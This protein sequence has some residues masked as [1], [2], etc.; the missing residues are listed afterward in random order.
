MGQELMNLEKLS[1]TEESR[2][3]DVNVQLDL[4][5]AAGAQQ[6]AAD[7]QEARSAAM[8]Q[9][10]QGVSSMAGYAAEMVPLY[11]QTQAS[12][13]FGAQQAEYSKAAA[14]GQLP[15]EFMING[16]PMSQQQAIQKKYGLDVGGMTQ[17]EF[18]SYMTGKGKKF[19]NQYDLFGPT[20]QQQ[21]L[22]P[23]GTGP[24]QPAPPYDPFSQF[25]TF[26]GY[27][28]MAP[29]ENPNQPRSI[30]DRF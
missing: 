15:A 24:M 27:G 6:A 29:S 1:A 26:P 12:K 19:V 3:R 20:T 9:G 11:M 2:L 21:Q 25:Q 8:A 7:A 22:M 30:W 28:V 10:F 17:S 4:G 23:P 16:K 13:Q 5:E 18:E 14:A